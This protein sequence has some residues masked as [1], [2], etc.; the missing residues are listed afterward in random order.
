MKVASSITVLGDT[1]RTIR[2]KKHWSQKKL[3]DKIGVCKR[4]IADIE[5]NIGNPKFAILCQLVKELDLPL[6][7]IFYPDAPESLE[8]KNAL[9]Q[10]ICECSEDEV[11]VLLAMVRS[12]K[13]TLRGK[14]EIELKETDFR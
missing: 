2:K 9:I 7:Q 6:Y 14:E 11:K 1:V 4:T 12:L 10:E 3:A 8:L 13:Q 5:S